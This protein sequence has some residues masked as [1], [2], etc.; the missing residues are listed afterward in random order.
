M[1][2]FQA[3]VFYDNQWP[4]SISSKAHVFCIQRENIIYFSFQITDCAIFIV[5]I[6]KLEICFKIG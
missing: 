3:I 2:F 1:K 5:S 4:I 6:A